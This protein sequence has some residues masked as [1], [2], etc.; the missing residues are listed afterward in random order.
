MSGGV[1]YVWDQTGDFNLNC[2]LGMV[3]LEPVE[4]EEDMAELQEMIEQHQQYTDSPVARQVL[5]QWPDVLSEF[6]KVMPI[7]YKRV[8]EQ[9][10]RETEENVGIAGS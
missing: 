7:D 6:I 5:E 10:R 3:Q 2:N 1:A 4:E 9:R 8:L